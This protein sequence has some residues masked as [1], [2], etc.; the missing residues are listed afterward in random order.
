MISLVHHKR[1]NFIL[2]KSSKLIMKR[3]LLIMVV[4]SMI[5]LALSACGGKGPLPPADKTPPSVIS[6]IPANGAQN[7]PV[8]SSV[9]I[10]FSEAMDAST[11]NEQ[12]IILSTGNSNIQGT[13]TYSGVTAIFKPTS[14]L[15]PKTVY[16]VAVEAGVKD[17]TGNALGSPYGYT[18]ITGI[19]VQQDTTPPRVIDIQPSSRKTEVSVNTLIVVM[20]SE[21]MDPT[22]I[23]KRNYSDQYGG[24]RL[25]QHSNALWIGS[26]H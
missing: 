20:F 15:N 4:L 26:Y 21:P 17:V 8:N 9:V 14:N 24:R 11:I 5:T 23:T 19:D 6:V 16:T 7:I 3:F 1:G 13:V 2:T 12:T 22:T 25:G 18:F 10:T